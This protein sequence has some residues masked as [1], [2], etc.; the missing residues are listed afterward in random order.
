MGIAGILR[1]IGTWF[2]ALGPRIWP[3]IAALMGQ[4]GAW[5]AINMATAPVRLALAVAVVTAWGVFLGIM[6]T[7]FD[8]LG[9]M[10]LLTT[11]PLTGMPADMYQLFCAVFPF[12]FLMR[13]TVAYVLWN[14]TFQAAAVVMMRVVR[15]IFGG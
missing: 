13:L 9:L 10:S 2:T 14:F 4:V 8:S 1:A 7:G 11:N 12:Q 3:Q 6:T 5:L 15:F